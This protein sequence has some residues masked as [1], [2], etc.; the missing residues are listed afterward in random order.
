MITSL[1]V[2]QFFCLS[3]CLEQMATETPISMPDH[4][5]SA[6]SSLSPGTGPQRSH[7]STQEQGGN[8]GAWIPKASSNN[9]WIQVNFGKPQI[10]SGIITKGR[11]GS[12]Q[13]VR[14]YYLLFSMDGKTFSYYEDEQ[15]VKKV[16]RDLL[17]SRHVF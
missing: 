14:A 7:L 3:E 4:S 5:L 11:D 15:G 16:S 10:V 13:F 8:S 9:D 17:F 6:S 1:V 12:Q 2:F